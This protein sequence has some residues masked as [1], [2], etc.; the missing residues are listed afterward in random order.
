MSDIGPV[1]TAVT[2]F[3]K[4]TLAVGIYRSGP[5]NPPQMDQECPEIAIL[6]YGTSLSSCRTQDSAPSAVCHISPCRLTTQPRSGSKKK[7]LSS[8]LPPWSIW[9][10]GDVFPLRDQLT[11]IRKG[12]YHQ[13]E[14]NRPQERR[15]KSVHGP[16]EMQ[17]CRMRIGGGQ[18]LRSRGAPATRRQINVRSAERSSRGKLGPIQ[19][20]A[21]RPHR[22][23]GMNP[24][25]YQKVQKPPCISTWIR[26]LRD[27]SSPK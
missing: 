24:G 26:S 25:R 18:V 5:D 10:R 9:E 14:E 12:G 2:S 16:I 3:P 15:G 11:S 1:G 21:H 20:S 19:I 22:S 17:M 7:P 6:L 4:N 8:Y 27:L 23:L 13:Q